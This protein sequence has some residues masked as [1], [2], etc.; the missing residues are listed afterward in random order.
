MKAIIVEVKGKHAAVLTDG[1][2][3][4][5]IKNRNYCIGQEIAIKNNSNKLIRMTAAAAAAI[6]IFVTPAWAYYTPYSYVSIDVNPSFEF[7]INRFDRVLT[8]KGFNDDGRELSKNIS[9]DGL[10]NKE[11]QSAVKSV[12]NELKTKGYIVEGEEDGV[13]IAASSKSD[14]KKDMLS[15]KLRTAVNEET[16]LKQTEDTEIETKQNS[17]F[18]KPG[19]PKKPEKPEEQDKPQDRGV[20]AE[21]ETE[22][23]EE[24]EEIKYDDK[25]QKPEKR[26]KPEEQEKPE[27]WEKSGAQEEREERKKSEEREPGKSDK[28]NKSERNNYDVQAIELTE[29]EVDEAKKMN[30]TLGKLNLIRK[31]QEAADSA[32]DSINPNEWSNESVQDINAKIKEYREILKQKEDNKNSNKN[33]QSDKDNRY[34]NNYS[35]RDGNDNNGNN[36]KAN[37]KH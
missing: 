7:Y 23:I 34:E 28:S 16:A 27:R 20:S 5:K 19:E 36:G 33:N 14:E 26:E 3:V 18:Q 24:T 32:G 8:V 30:V 11:I 37:K 15:K 35:D 17:E 2:V 31:L 6:M 9:I 25:S 21:Q 10:K 22:I 4:S 12:L 13:I 29:Q 1:G